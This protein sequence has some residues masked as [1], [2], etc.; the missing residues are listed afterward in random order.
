MVKSLVRTAIVSCACSLVPMALAEEMIGFSDLSGGGGGLPTIGSGGLSS[1][2]LGALSSLTGGGKAGGGDLSGLGGLGGGGLGS[3][4]SLTGGGKAGLP[5][6][7]SGGL[8]GLSSKGGGGLSGLPSMSSLPSIGSGGL[9]GLGGTTAKQETRA[10]DAVVANV[11]PNANL[12][13]LSP[14]PAEDSEFAAERRL[15]GTTM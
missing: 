5:S 10:G 2:G 15:R 4:S 1:G 14:S 12:R 9:S 13:E 3:L 6:F 8:S 7:S 11:A